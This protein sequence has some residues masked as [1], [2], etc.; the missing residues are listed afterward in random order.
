MTPYDD[1]EILEDKL[2]HKVDDR[3]SVFVGSPVSAVKELVTLRPDQ[4][5][6]YK[7]IN[8]YTG[9]VEHET[10]VLAQ[11]IATA[12]ALSR[13]VKHLLEVNSTEASNTLTMH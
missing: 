6:N 5:K 3:Y 11:A 4:L 8:V 9:V 1:V 2:V 12:Q 7:V 13:Q 10:T